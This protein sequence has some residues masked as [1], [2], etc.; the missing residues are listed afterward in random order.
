M[1]P[2]HFRILLLLCIS[3]SVL[4]GSLWNNLMGSVPTNLLSDYEQYWLAVTKDFSFR[5]ASGMAWDKQFA[6]ACT[7]GLV[8]RLLIC[9]SAVG[10][11]LF[12]PWSRRL[13]LLATIPLFPVELLIKGPTLFSE[14][15]MAL[16][17]AA[18]FLWGT[19]ISAAYL[20][21]VKDRFQAGMKTAS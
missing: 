15:S 9:V 11:L 16:N 3:T 18:Y 4:F 5:F 21:N 13:A 19:V 6:I 10:M 20:S 7:L 12:K 8:L 1:K 14:A 17:D 2:A